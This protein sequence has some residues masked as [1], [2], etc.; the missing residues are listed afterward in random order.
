MY[1]R[2][3]CPYI[4]Y[5]CEIQDWIDSWHIVDCIQI[6]K[7]NKQNYCHSHKLDFIF[8]DVTKLLLH[9]MYPLPSTFVNID[10]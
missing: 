2:I 3:N 7:K 5:I 6:I 9:E 8:L 4:I 1:L 10:V